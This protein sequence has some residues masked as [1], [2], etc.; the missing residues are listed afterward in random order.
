MGIMYNM[1][2]RKNILMNNPHGGIFMCKT[3]DGMIGIAIGDALGVPVEFVPRNELAKDPV[4]SMRGY[5]THHQPPGTWSDDTSLTLALLDSLVKNHSLH[6]EDIM[7]KFSEWLLYNEYT[8]TG[9]VFDVGNATARAIMNYGRG[10]D[11]LLCGGPSQY[12][13]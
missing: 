2:G 12:D 1:S 9:D 11:P 13:N 6:Y 8:A 4:T 10:I 3:Y 7:D 5:G